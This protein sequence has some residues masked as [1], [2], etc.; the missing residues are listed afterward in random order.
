MGAHLDVVAFPHACAQ[1]VQ[2]SRQV[3][4]TTALPKVIGDAAGEAQWSESATQT[5][6]GQN[7]SGGAWGGHTQWHGGNEG[8]GKTVVEKETKTQSNRTF[9][10]GWVS[11]WRGS[12]VTMRRV[13]VGC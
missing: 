5:W 10:V 6:T 11:D 9:G 4:R 2:S 13:R 8:T 3:W 12:G 1:R 7:R